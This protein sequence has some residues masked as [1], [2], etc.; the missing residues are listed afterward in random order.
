MEILKHFE[1]ED[2][3]KYILYRLRKDEWPN[4][5]DKLPTEFRLCY[6]TDELLEESCEKGG[7]SKSDFL[8]RYILP[9]EPTIK[10]GDFGEI[11]CFHSTIEN[12][13]NK[14]KALFAP[15][16][17]QWKDS[18]NKAAPGADSILFHTV[19]KT[20]SPKDILVT[21]ESKMKAVKSSA[22][23]IQDAIDGA[24]LDKLSRMA[25]TLSWLEEKYARQG[26]NENRKLVER[27][28]DPAVYGD[29]QKQY[30]A[31]A[32]IDSAFETTETIK[33]IKNEYNVSVIIFSIDELKKAYE[34]TRTNILKSV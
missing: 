28:K 18:R 29:Y 22:N 13:K 7:F 25:K 17:W 9:D 16:K 8:E 1:R 12:F 32:I 27:F 30:K 5:L 6:I 11:L 4:F 15:R 26:E 14:G 20:P 19:N 3:E 2:T 21:I 10:S 24:N 23:R 34:T 31:V 33:E